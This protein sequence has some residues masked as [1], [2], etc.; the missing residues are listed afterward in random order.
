[1]VTKFETEIVRLYL[2][3][4]ALRLIPNFSYYNAKG[5]KKV[6]PEFY[7]IKNF[8]NIKN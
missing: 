5:K 8:S 3:I 2:Y 7:I 1:M 4:A 6:N